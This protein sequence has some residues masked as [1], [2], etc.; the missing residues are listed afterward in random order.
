MVLPVK[1]GP[2][3]V[4]TYCLLM[5]AVVQVMPNVLLEHPPVVEY[6]RGN[7][8]LMFT[9]LLKTISGELDITKLTVVKTLAGTVAG[10]VTISLLTEKVSCANAMIAIN[11]IYLA[12]IYFLI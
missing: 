1:E 9:L 10:V 8:I 7:V 11:C 2:V 3:A 6:P 5:T 4:K 12:G